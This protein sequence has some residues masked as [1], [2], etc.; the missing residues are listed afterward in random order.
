MGLLGQKGYQ[1]QHEVQLEARQL[2]GG[3]TGASTVLTFSLMTQVLEQRAP[4]A[5]SQ[6]TQN[7]DEQ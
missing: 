5:S 6:T 3:D 1:G 7:L 2:T 4:S